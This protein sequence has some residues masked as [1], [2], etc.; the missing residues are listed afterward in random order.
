MNPKDYTKEIYNALY[1]DEYG[2]IVGLDEVMTLD[3]PIQDR[4]VLL[5]S[6]LNNEDLYVA[7]QSA[8]ILTAWG[9][10]HGVDFLI[11][12]IEKNVSSEINLAPNRFN[13]FDD[14]YDQIGSTVRLYELTEGNS[15]KVIKCY[16]LLL[17]KFP[18]NQFRGHFCDSLTNSD[19]SAFLHDELIESHELTYSRGYRFQASLLLPCI[20]KNFPE[21]GANLIDTYY[22]RSWDINQPEM[23]FVAESLGIG[24]ATKFIPILEKLVSSKNQLTAEKA[25]RSLTILRSNVR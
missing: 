5:E 21:E 8:S 18:F 13:N 20:M 9:N 10:N 4:I 14:I 23:E 17:D 12:L 2:D 15:E 24:N 7:Y 22:L 19:L 11:Q 6:L 1:S 3:H 25:Q 16:R